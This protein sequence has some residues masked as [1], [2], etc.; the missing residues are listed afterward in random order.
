MDVIRSY[1]AGFIFTTSLP[2]TVLRGAK[3]SIEVLRG[4]EGRSLRRQHGENVR[5]LRSKLFEVGV[6]AVHTPSHIIPIHVGDPSTCSRISDELIRRYGHYVQA[7]NY[8]TVARG[9]ES[10]RVAPTPHHTK[11]MMDAFV[12]DVAAIWQEVGLELKPRP[13]PSSECPTGA[14]QC[15][16]C[17]RPMHFDRLEARVKPCQKAECPAAGSVADGA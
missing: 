1:G 6:A 7:I 5:Y 4:D 11:E 15:D 17:R 2:P 10:L 9:Q 13:S 16:Y 3:T 14:P 8:P 12:R